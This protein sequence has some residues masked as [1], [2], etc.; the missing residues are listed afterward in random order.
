MRGFGASRPPKPPAAQ[1]RLSSPGSSPAL[2]L[3]GRNLAQA[4]CGGPISEDTHG[5]WS[6]H[7]VEI[8]A[9]DGEVFALRPCGEVLALK[10]KDT[11]RQALP[12]LQEVLLEREMKTV[13]T[14]KAPDAAGRHTTET[15][16][17]TETGKAARSPNRPCRR[18]GTPQSGAPAEGGLRWQHRHSSRTRS[19]CGSCSP[20]GGCSK[21]PGSCGEED[22][23]DAASRW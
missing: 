21:C 8:Q 17:T 15:T 23:Q 2:Q 22:R 9:E 6:P 12:S 4:K 16:K 13:K 14:V 1:Q 11:A 7:T 18:P 3:R 5:A 20:A 19:T 10:P